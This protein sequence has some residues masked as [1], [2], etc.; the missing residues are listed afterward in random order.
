MTHF[1]ICLGTVLV[2]WV[3]ADMKLILPDASP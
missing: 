2:E 3:T 1:F